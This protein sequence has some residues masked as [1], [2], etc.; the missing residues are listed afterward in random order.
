MAGNAEGALKTAAKRTGLSPT[1]YL[2][3]LNAGLRWCFRDQD[4]EPAANFGKDGSRSDGLDRS[5]RRS[6]N[7]AARRAYTPKPR[8]AAGRRFVEPRDGDA[9]QAR[10]RVN[11]LVEAGLLPAPSTLACVDC[12]HVWR[13]GERRHEYDHHKGYTPEHHEDVEPVCSTCHHSR[14]KARRG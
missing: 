14:E 9:L 12:E 1:E 6:R 8:P 11:Y 4:W 13:P 7:A 5:C 10:R 2:D 3:R